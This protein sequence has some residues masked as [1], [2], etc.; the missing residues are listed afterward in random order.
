MCKFRPLSRSSF[1]STVTSAISRTAGCKIASMIVSIPATST[2]TNTA[3]NTIKRLCAVTFAIAFTSLLA[4]CAKPQPEPEPIDPTTANGNQL[5]ALEYQVK[6][7]DNLV[8]IAAEIT[9]NRDNWRRIADFNS[10]QNPATLVVGQRIWIPKDLV[11]L[12]RQ[13]TDSRSV[14]GHPD[15]V[16]NSVTLPTVIKPTGIQ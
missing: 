12:N 15:A 1:S 4:S 3:A 9:R 10:I 2:I 11:P 7:G 5:G 8:L 13:S 6:Q 16:V 14:A